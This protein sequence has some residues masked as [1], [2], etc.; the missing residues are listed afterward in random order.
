MYQH[1]TAASW[2]LKSLRPYSQLCEF[3]F[4][5]SAIIPRDWSKRIKA[6]TKKRPGR[7]PGKEKKKRREGLVSIRKFAHPNLCTLGGVVC[8]LLQVLLQGIQLLGEPPGFRG[9]WWRKGSGES[10]N[11]SRVLK[12]L[13]LQHH[14]TLEAASFWERKDRL[15]FSFLATLQWMSINQRALMMCN[16]STQTSLEKGGSVPSQLA[17]QCSLTHRLH[18]FYAALWGLQ[19]KQNIFICQ[20]A[21][22]YFDFFFFFLSSHEWGIS[23][24]SNLTWKELAV[25][26]RELEGREGNSSIQPR[27][28]TALK[29]TGLVNNVNFMVH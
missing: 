13:F 23:S 1:I 7:G 25:F 10:N 16:D 18:Y 6:E 27:R 3:S 29:R 15:P 8:K 14:V 2:V 21:H 28:P 11:R 22:F 20:R 26:A 12:E 17:R 9:K 24:C 5:N 19:R 4:L